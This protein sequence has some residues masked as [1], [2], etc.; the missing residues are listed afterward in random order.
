ME[1]IY[2]RL[3]N[4][5]EKPHPLV[6]MGL[7]LLLSYVGGRLANL[8]KAPRVS[9]YLVT[10][11]ILSPSVL[12]LFHERLV[13]EELT[14]ITDIALAIIAFSIG[15]G[16]GLAKMKR[17]GR[18]ILWITSTEAMGAFIVVT[19]FLSLF[20]YLL[21]GSGT[22][23]SPFWEI[24]FPIALVIGA[25][26]AATAPA[27]TLAIIHEYRAKGPLTTIL[28]GVVAMD[29]GVAIF[30]FA[31]ASTMAQSLIN[32]GGVTL[33][34]FLLSPVLSILTS[35]VIGG[36]LGLCFRKLIRFVRRREAMLGIMVGS[37]FLVSGLALSLKVSPLLAN[38]ILGFMVTNFVDHHED[39]F[40]V[41]EN[42]EEPIF[43]MF[44]TL[45]GA[46]MDLRVM[47]TAGW[48]ALIITLA[49][50][51]GKLLG[52]RLGAQISRAPQVVKKYL[53]LTLL[54]TAGVAVGLVLEAKEIFGP[55]QLSELMVNAVLGAVII[56]ELLTPFF[57]RFSLKKAGEIIRE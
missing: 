38:M 53:G 23:S 40:A 47:Q 55:T 48:V 25:I 15:G 6:Y 36:L 42:I 20:F 54:P 13:K 37:I 17:L 3:L 31:F 11:M 2:F 35:L 34:N 45:A 32:H 33:Q 9:G 21:H 5:I 28:L 56:N 1:T 30:F 14:L 10:G 22:I 4:L 52:S 50:F 24:Y 12:G 57:V 39:L 44:F 16:L 27:A 49:R 43:G 46:H 18:H 41:V 29:D 19:M 26:S 7:L 51:G 8:L